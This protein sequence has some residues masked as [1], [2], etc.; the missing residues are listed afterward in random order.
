MSIKNCILNEIGFESK[1]VAIYIKIKIFSIYNNLFIITKIFYQNYLEEHSKK[2]HK[3]IWPNYLPTNMEFDV[4]RLAVAKV[5]LQ[6]LKTLN[7]LR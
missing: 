1:L 7:S 4:L 6:K 3:I 2:S 5:L